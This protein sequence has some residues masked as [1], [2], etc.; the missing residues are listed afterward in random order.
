MAVTV[1][2]GRIISRRI[3]KKLREKGKFY[4]P[5]LLIGNYSKSIEFYEK[6]RKSPAWGYKPIG[7]VL[8][9]KNEYNSLANSLDSV[10]PPIVG[11][12]DDLEGILINMCPEEVLI[13]IDSSHRELLLYITNKCAERGIKVK[14]VPD[15]YD[16][17]TGLVRTLPLYG[18][19]LIEIST[20]LLK[21]WEESI[22]RI[23]DIIFSFLVVIIGLPFWLLTG[24][25]IKLESV[26][27]IF[28]KQER[29]GKDNKPF[30]LY[31]FRSMKAGSDKNGPQWT[32]VNDPRVTKLGYILRKTHIDEIPQFLNVLKGQ[33]SIV[34][35]RPEITAIV[36]KYS[37][38]LPYYKRR[39]VVRPGIT[40]WWQVNYTSYEETTEE[41][42][43][44]LKDDFYYIEN[45]SLKL[46]LEIMVRTVVLMIK[47]HGQT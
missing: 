33:M 35:P 31:K 21:P 24:L 36:A 11:L 8:T 3:Q 38:I 4:I 5:A 10:S 45:M 30:I 7:L 46:D 2:S 25:A 44:R 14:I 18:I 29:V 9:D 40:G 15:L 12:I 37:L 1:S 19:P 28:Y 39:L 22:K 26:G 13:T 43:S 6:I 34:G 27:T 42:E 41:I 47:G 32:Q 17:I 23:I 20:Q 16:I